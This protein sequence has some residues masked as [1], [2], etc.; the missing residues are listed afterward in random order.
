MARSAKL[1]DSNRNPSMK[2]IV[3]TPGTSA[4]FHNLDSRFSILDHYSDFSR[5]PSRS[6]LWCV[7]STSAAAPALHSM[8]ANPLLTSHENRP[9]KSAH[10]SNRSQEPLDKRPSCRTTCTALQ[11]STTIEPQQYVHKPPTYRL[12]E[13][14]IG[15]SGARAS[16]LTV[17]PASDRHGRL[18]NP[19]DSLSSR[20][21]DASRGRGC[22]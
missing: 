16:L 2:P 12:S 4:K 14:T 21:V 3:S 22:L 9:R 18:S 1:L 8:S 10:I 15:G 19:P 13:T 20:L 7:P 6:L 17:V 11:V 5:P